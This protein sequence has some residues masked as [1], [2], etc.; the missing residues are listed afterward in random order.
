MSQHYQTA[1]G[2]PV[3][4]VAAR[5]PEPKSEPEPEPITTHTD[6]LQSSS[7]SSTAGECLDAILR[8]FSES[9]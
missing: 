3:G 8:V 4:A 7:Q 5:F 2:P 6:C 9:S 1:A